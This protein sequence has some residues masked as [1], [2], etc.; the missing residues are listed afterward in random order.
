MPRLDCKLG[1]YNCLSVRHMCRSSASDSCP[2]RPETHRSR[3]H[4]NRVKRGSD[5]E[6]SQGDVNRGRSLDHFLEAIAIL[7]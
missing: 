3:E 4:A 1:G 2:I 7:D 5:E 6:I